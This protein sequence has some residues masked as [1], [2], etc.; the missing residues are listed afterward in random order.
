MSARRGGSYLMRDGKRE[1]VGR[2]RQRGEAPAGGGRADPSRAGKPAAENPR[3]AK[4]D[5]P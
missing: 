2:T 4:A 3:P 1:L 5:K